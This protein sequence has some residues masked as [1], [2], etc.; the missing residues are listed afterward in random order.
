M[1]GIFAGEYL[2]NRYKEST[3]IC[4]RH[5]GQIEQSRSLYSSNSSLVLVLY[6]YNRYHNITV[7]LSLSLT[8]CKPINIDLCRYDIL[9]LKHDENMDSCKKYI[10]STMK[11]SNI[12][13]FQYEAEPFLSFNLQ[14][15]ECSIVQFSSQYIKLPKSVKDHYVFSECHTNFLIEGQSYFTQEKQIQ[16]IIK[17]NFGKHSRMQNDSIQLLGQP[18]NLQIYSPKLNY[19]YEKRYE[20]N[21]FSSYYIFAQVNTPTYF[22]EFKIK[23][24]LTLQSKSWIDI[25]VKQN[26]LNETGVSKVGLEKY[27]SETFHPKEKHL[28]L[29]KMYFAHEEVLLLKV[30]GNNSDQVIPPEVI[31]SISMVQDFGESL[32]WIMGPS[33]G[34]HDKDARFGNPLSITGILKHMGIVYKMG[35]CLYILITFYLFIFLSETI[36]FL[37]AHFIF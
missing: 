28:M 16:F 32:F 3:T 10:N 30:G 12:K 20:K 36:A 17:G 14:D 21:I 37:S 8:R 34:Y 35:G 27:T 31:L 26:K 22:N 9:C 13:L 7:S 23:M 11:W 15:N 18:D 6:W 33:T 5:D 4:Q 29:K 2:D 25:I 1:G 19:R 24:F